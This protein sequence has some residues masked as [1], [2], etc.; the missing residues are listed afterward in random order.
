MHFTNYAT[1]EFNI[2]MNLVT[3]CLYVV[4]PFVAVNIL[5][6][7]P[8]P[9]SPNSTIYFTLEGVKLR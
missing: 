5:R 6:I 7:S 2:I 8:L 9:L 4:F 3:F 1:N